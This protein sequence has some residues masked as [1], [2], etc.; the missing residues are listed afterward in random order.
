M[1]PPFLGR[2]RGGRRRRGF[3]L[4]ALMVA[5]V[6]LTV[7]IITLAGANAQTATMQ[8][9]SQNRTNAIAIAR[10]YMEQIHT[11][12]PW[13]IASESS[14]NVDGEGQMTSL[15]AYKR[16]VDVEIL[17]PS[18]ISIV[19][20]VHYPRGAQPVQLT[21]SFFRGSGVAGP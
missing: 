18:L 16:I 1:T 6:L 10:A 8:T 17:K 14:T 20:R 19:V 2:P 3:T 11:R 15:G 9:L 13:T 7:G 12:D 5:M 21:T 4:V